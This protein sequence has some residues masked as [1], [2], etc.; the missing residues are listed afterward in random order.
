M[1]VKLIKIMIIFAIFEFGLVVFSF[2][3]ICGIDLK[4]KIIEYYGPTL[5][6]VIVLAS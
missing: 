4:S 6:A 3:A 2:I 5:T 1:L